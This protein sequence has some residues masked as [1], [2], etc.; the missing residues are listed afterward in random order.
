VHGFVFAGDVIGVDPVLHSLDV[1][2]VEDTSLYALSV[3][4]LHLAMEADL[5]F[6]S[7]VTALG[8]RLLRSMQ[9]HLT[10]VTRLAAGERIAHFLMQLSDDNRRCGRDP[11]RLR[12]PMRRLDIADYLGL[13]V[14][15][16]CRTLTSFRHAGLITADHAGETRVTDIRAMRA[17][18]RGESDPDD[19]MRRAS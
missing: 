14:E 1:E 13:T 11:L 17:L 19:S 10:A 2:A 7:A 4:Q 8:M 15:T 18:A 3:S 12:I 16:V 9:A 6:S 5:E